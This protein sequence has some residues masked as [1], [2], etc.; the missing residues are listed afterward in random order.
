MEGIREILKLYEQVDYAHRMQLFL[1]FPDLRDVFEDIEL[2]SP[3]VDN[4]H[5]VSEW[6]KD[7]RK[8]L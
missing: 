6:Q 2:T 8:I 3:A 4:D 5:I 7:M 1:Q